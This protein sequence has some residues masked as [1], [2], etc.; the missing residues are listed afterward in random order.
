MQLSRSYWLWQFKVTLWGFEFIS[1][2]HLSITKEGLNQMRLAPLTTTAYLLH[3]LNPT[4]SHHL[5]S[6]LNPLL[7]CQNV[8]RDASFFSFFTRDWEKNNKKH[9][10]S[11]EIGNDILIFINIKR[12]FQIEIDYT[13]CLWNSKMLEYNWARLMNK[14]MHAVITYCFTFLISEELYI[15]KMMNTL[16]KLYQALF[17]YKKLAADDDTFLS[18]GWSKILQ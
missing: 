14:C 2:Y 6:I 16:L 10:H 3:L 4:P 18:W 17:M 8:R 15:T 13:G 9:F 11:V 1:N 5:S 12:V 7:V